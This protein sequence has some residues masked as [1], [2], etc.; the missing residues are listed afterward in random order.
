MKLFIRD[1]FLLIVLQL[2]QMITI[3]SLLWLSD[4]HEWSIVA[5]SLLLCSVFL[6]SYLVYRY[7]SHRNLYSMLTEQISTLDESLQP[8]DQQPISLALNQL[9]R[10]QY[11]HFQTEL[12]SLHEKQKEQLV[13]ID[14]WV[15]QMKTP[16]SVIELMAH[17]LDEPE[18]SSLREEVDRLKTGLT[19]ALHMARLR[20]LEHDFTVKRVN[21]KTVIQEILAENRR[22]FIRH[23]IYPKLKVEENI[24]INTDEK[25]FH[26][27]VNQIIEN[28]LKYSIGRSD[29]LEISANIRAN[30]ALLSITDFGIGIPKEDI[31]GIFKPFY[32]GK[33]GRM[34][35][36]STGVGL[37]LVKEVLTHLGHDIKVESE[38]EKG[39][40]FEIIF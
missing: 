30:K 1:H 21:L 31:R 33:N 29:V 39:T 7:V 6:L 10:K 22:L 11:D 4:I 12:I 26:F 8:L 14:R 40:T 13:F 36:E 19:T 34:Y 25:W 3:V 28:A 16:L 35:R 9:L 32:T 17:E 5:Y 27:I 2:G 15:H 23:G 24:F 20:N 37:Y 18:A 38:V